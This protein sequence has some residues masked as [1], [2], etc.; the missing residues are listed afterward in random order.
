MAYHRYYCNFYGRVDGGKLFAML[1]M[2]D[3]SFSCVDTQV[4]G[5]REPPVQ[6]RL[7]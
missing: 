2:N 4:F 5:R 3:G 7:V 1:P 6:L